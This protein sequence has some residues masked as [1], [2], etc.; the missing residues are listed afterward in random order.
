[1]ILTH[2]QRA[3]RRRLHT[4]VQ[5]AQAHPQHHHQPHANGHSQEGGSGAG[6][7]TA[8]TTPG[9]N[10]PTP[11]SDAASSSAAEVNR[12]M[13]DTFLEL[14]TGNERAFQLFRSAQDLLTLGGLR[15][16]LPSFAA[17]ITGAHSSDGL[18]LLGLAPPDQM[19]EPSR[20]WTF[21]FGIDTNVNYASIGQ[22]VCFGRALL[23]DLAKQAEVQ[24]RP[25]W[26]PLPLA[27]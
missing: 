22:A 19:S 2:M 6:A 13:Q 17:K 27:S 9:S 21:A 24:W 20:P 26:E 8:G 18:P 11:P 16:H 5:H 23:E 4:I 12:Q 14:S 3:E 10:I 1:M 25:E 15:A 7:A